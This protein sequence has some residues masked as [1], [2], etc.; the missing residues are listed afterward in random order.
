MYAGNGSELSECSCGYSRLDMKGN[1]Q[2]RNVLN[3]VSLLMKNNET[4][5]MYRTHMSRVSVRVASGQITVISLYS[6]GRKCLTCR[7]VN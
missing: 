4:K 6:G 2:I 5:M 7:V 3:V 1:E